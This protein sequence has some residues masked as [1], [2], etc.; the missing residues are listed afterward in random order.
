MILVLYL[1]SKAW[2]TVPFIH[3]AKLAAPP[4]TISLACPRTIDGNPPRAATAPVVANKRRRAKVLKLLGMAAISP[5]CTILHFGGVQSVC[6][7]SLATAL[8]AGHF[9]FQCLDALDQPVHG[10]RDLGLAVARHDVLRAVGVPGLDG[11]H[12]RA[13]R[14]GLVGGIDQPLHQ[15]DVALD[16]PRAAPQLD[17]LL[18]GEVQDEDVGAIVLLEMTERDVLP[19]AGEVGE[20]EF[21][22]ADR[23]QETRR[24]AAMLDI[25]PAVGAGGRK[26]EGIDGVEELAEIV[27]DLGLPVAAFER[28]PRSETRLLC[29]DRKSVV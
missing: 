4:T 21:A 26:K 27:G 22:R 7:C 9:L 17:P 18:R 19:I 12:D 6:Q 14:P 1:A 5:G 16:D 20:S 15:L 29:L 3:G 2:A 28:L 10:R 23:L 13:P 25:R 24:S 8:Q 11:E